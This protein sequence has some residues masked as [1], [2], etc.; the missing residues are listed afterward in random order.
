M[1]IVVPNEENFRIVEDDELEH[2]H[3]LEQVPTLDEFDMDLSE[4][5]R[6]RDATPVY[7]SVVK[8]GS[9]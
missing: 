9:E 6:R 8:R 2:E 1:S 5:R 7:R 4:F 3:E